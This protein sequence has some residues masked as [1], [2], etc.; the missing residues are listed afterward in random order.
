MMTTPGWIAA[1]FS[2]MASTSTKP[3]DLKVTAL[4][5]YAVKGLSADALEHVDLKSNCFPD[6]RRFALLQNGRKWKEKEWLHKENFLC[7]FT[8][9]DLLAKFE[10]SYRVVQAS[11]DTGV[12]IEQRILEMRDRASG[13][14]LVGPLHMETEQGRERLAAFLSEQSGEEVVCVTSIDGAFQFGNTSSGFK[15]GDANARTIHVSFYRII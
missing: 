6:D 7:A 1:T 11:D 12:D 8:H 10:S 14:M 15:N 9:P 3:Y 2:G 5:R 4:N 13:K